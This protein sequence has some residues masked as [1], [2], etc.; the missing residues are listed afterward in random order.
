VWTIFPLFQEDSVG[1]KKFSYRCTTA[2][3]RCES[4]IAISNMAGFDFSV[5]P[6]SFYNNV[7]MMNDGTCILRRRYKIHYSSAIETTLLQNHIIV[8][9]AELKE[10]SFLTGPLK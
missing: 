8:S 6:S 4:S 2:L 7:T 10:K 9:L 3:M 5:L 1:I